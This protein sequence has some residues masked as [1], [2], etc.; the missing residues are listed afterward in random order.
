MLESSIIS[1]EDEF[2]SLASDWNKLA[3]RTD[4]SSV[5]LRHE[6]NDAAWQ[7]LKKD[8]CELCIVCVRRDEELIGLCPLVRR[9]TV[10]AGIRL[11]ELG[12]LAVPDT[13]EFSVIANPADLGD[14]VTGLM[15][16]L[17]SGTVRWDIMNLEKLPAD[18][19]ATK[20]LED[21]ARTCG[22][23]VQ[24]LLKH[25]NPGIDLQDDW[26][27][28]YGRRS[29]RLKKGNNLVRNR[30]QRDDKVVEIRCF[31]SASEGF[32]LARLLE[33]LTKLSAS[34]WKASTGLTLNNPGPGAFLARLSEHAVNNSWLLVW[35]LTIDQEPAAMEYQL[36]FN[37]VISALRADYDGK[38]QDYSPGTL[39]N[40]RII[41][42][43]F[44]RE[45]SY[46]ALGP[47]SNPYKSRWV[48][49]ARE[50]RDVIM[51]GP[52]IRARALHTLEMHIKPLLRR[53]LQK[54]GSD[55][56]REP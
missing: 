45:A 46:Y 43:L 25:D 23:D 28:Y 48:E 30:L 56:S 34:S 42:R 15:N 6:W 38:F 10:R 52:S 41:E 2:C 21:T 24:T 17:K 33:T 3:H 4:Q 54:T 1:D 35:L 44:E 53:I 12:G 47:G 19:P 26:E 8:D 18:L 7:W 37:G 9:Q 55:S 31:D 20:V 36:E 32:E 11:N 39:L 14:V 16:I 22:Y 49:E 29:R 50:L 51:Y 40:W 5:F 27:A 13:Q